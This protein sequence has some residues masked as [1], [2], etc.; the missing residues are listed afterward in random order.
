MH[1]HSTSDSD[2]GC[3]HGGGR[4]LRPGDRA[5]HRARAGRDHR[6][7]QLVEEVRVSRTVSQF[8]F[9]AVL[10]NPGA[11]LAGATARVVSLSPRTVIVD[12]ELRFGAIAT[13][14]SARSVD[15]FSVRQDRTALFNPT[16]LAWTI[17]PDAANQPPTAAIAAVGA[18]FVAQAVTLD[19]RGS[20]DRKAVL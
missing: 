3:A 19:G 17:T 2:P 14:G 18:V 7:V 15:T 12:S 8:T 5:A 6:W 1:A 11:A 4:L 16:D 13:A 9:A 20:S 10:T